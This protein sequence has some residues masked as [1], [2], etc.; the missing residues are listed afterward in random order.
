MMTQD[1]I[2]DF[3]LMH[4]SEGFINGL[5][6]ARSFMVGWV[7]NAPNLTDKQKAHIKRG[8]DEIIANCADIEE[9]RKENESYKSIT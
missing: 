1:D 3:A 2:V 7:S 9:E 8:L 6:S 5:I 4:R